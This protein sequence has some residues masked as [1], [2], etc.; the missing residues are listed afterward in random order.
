MR[1]SPIPF[2]KCLLTLC[3]AA[4]GVLWLSGQSGPPVHDLAPGR[5]LVA[6]RGLLDP[7]FHETVILLV[8]L[9]KDGAMGLVLNRPT[10][11]PLSQAFKD[12]DTDRGGD[13]PVY[14]GGPVSPGGVLALVRST[15]AP[16]DCERIVGDVFFVSTAAPLEKALTSGAG[17]GRLRVF[18][19]Y[20]G[21]GAGQLDRE[22]L[23]GSWHVF[24][25]DPSL[26]F[27]SKPDSLWDRFIR[28]TELRIAGLR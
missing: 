11:I 13:G 8:T 21:W 25:A 24:E 12:Y 7:N 16:P 14:I 10:D 19:G 23:T 28:R 9:N 20:S 6:Q 22:I 15:S 17:P 4:A 1:W 5:F 3:L 27:D 2:R 26:V 18:S